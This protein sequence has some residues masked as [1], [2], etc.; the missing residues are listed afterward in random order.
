LGFLTPARRGQ[1]VPIAH[2]TG[3]SG[4]EAGGW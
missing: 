4:F 1:V 2:A 3:L